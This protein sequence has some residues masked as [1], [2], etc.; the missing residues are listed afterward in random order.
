[1]QHQEARIGWGETGD[2]RAQGRNSYYGELGSGDAR[3]LAY[4]ADE[5]APGDILLVLH[6]AEEF[7]AVGVVTGDYRYDQAAPSSIR[8]EYQRVRAVTWLHRDLALSILPLNDNTLFTQMTVYP[9][10]RIA[11]GDLLS[12]LERAGAEPVPQAA[13]PDARK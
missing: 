9:L 8:D 12:Y 5:I 4:F 2:L 6:S 3:T 7:S 13:L 1:M 11:W 10:D